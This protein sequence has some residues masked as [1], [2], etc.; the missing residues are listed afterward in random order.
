MDRLHHD[1]KTCL[2]LQFFCCFWLFSPAVYGQ[3]APAASAE[4]IQALQKKLDALQSQ[5][6]EVQGE[7]QRLSG[8]TAPPPTHEPADLSAQQ[9]LPSNKKTSPRSRRN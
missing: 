4:Q 9:S 6:A 2:S 1:Q 7:L 8:G 3:A 5:M